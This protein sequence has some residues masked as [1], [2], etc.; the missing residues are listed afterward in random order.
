MHKAQY[1]LSLCLCISLSESC[2]VISSIMGWPLLRA[3]WG[4]ELQRCSNNCLL[5]WNPKLFD[6]PFLEKSFFSVLK[7]EK[8]PSDVCN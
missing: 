3:L 6:D 1:I 2:C 4:R 8:P 7:P 5:N